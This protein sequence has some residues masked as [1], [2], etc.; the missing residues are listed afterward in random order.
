MS[1]N[2]D[3]G[4]RDFMKFLG[5]RIWIVV[6]CAAILGASVLIYTK[7]F[8]E[9]QY[10]ASISVYVNNSTGQS[11]SKITSSDLQAALRLVAT[12][13]NIIQSNTVLDKVIE[14][15]DVN[16]TAGQLR[17]MISAKSIGDTEMFQVTVRSTDPQMSMDLAN[18]IAEVAP[19]EIS[20]FIEGSTTKIIDLA[21]LPTAPCAP[22]YML[23]TVLGVMIGG[24]L[25]ILGLLVYMLLDT[26]IKTEEDLGRICKIPVMGLIPNLSVDG[27]KTAQ[28]GRR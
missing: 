16:L 20:Q 17:G 8:V 1:E 12:Y 19:K 3:V 9:P 2:V 4:L 22:N 26:R 7:S 18:V 24:V 27:K 13:I 23:N 15:C 21:K 10:E 14:T 5:K 28:K 11:G 6:L 25:A